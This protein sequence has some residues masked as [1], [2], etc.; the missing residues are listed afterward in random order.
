MHKK[1]VGA[2]TLTLPLVTA[3]GERMHSGEI[4]GLRLPD[5]VVE[6]RDGRQAG[7]TGSFES[8]AQQRILFGD[9]HVHTTFSADAFEASLPMLSGEGA[10]PPADAC[11]FAR[12]CA[13]LDFWA[14]TE[15]AEFLTPQRWREVQ[16]TVRQCDALGAGAGGPDLV[17]FLGWEWTQIGATPATHFGHKN[18][19]LREIDA[20]SAPVRPIAYDAPME[21]RFTV[22]L[23]AGGMFADLLKRPW[24]DFSNRDVYWDHLRYILE[25]FRVPRCPDGVPSPEL[26]ADCR[27][28]ASTPDVL[29]RKLREW[30]G[31]SFVIPHGNTWGLYTPPGTSWDKQLAGAMHDPERQTLIEVYSGHGSAEEYRDWR[32]IELDESGEAICP[33]PR[34]DFTPCCWQAGELARERCEDEDPRVCEELAREA[35]RNYV[36][37]GASGHLTL[38]D[39]EPE[40]WLDCGQCRDCFLPAFNHRPGSSVQA[41]LAT[42]RFENGAKQRFF[43]GLIASSD[44]H[45]ARPGTGYKEYARTRM[46]DTAGP[47]DASWAERLLD[48]GTGGATILTRPPAKIRI[49][50]PHAVYESERRAS[51]LSTGGLVAAHASSRSREAI[52]DA[53][54][55]REVYGTSGPRILL[56]F[57]LLNGFG[58]HQ[59]MGS[60]AQLDRVPRF[61]VRAAGAFEQRAGCPDS[62]SALRA[63]RLARLCAGECYHPSDRRHP[64]VRI[65]VVR[66]RAQLASDKDFGDRIDDPWRV[67]ECPGEGEGCEVEFEDPDFPAA[68]RDSLYYVR[69]IQAQTPAVNGAGLR[70]E[71]DEA[72]ACVRTRPCHGGF[73]T[74][75]DDDCLAPVEQRAWSSPIFLDHAA[76]R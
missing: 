25:T 45:S 34:P 60:R 38:P 32:A 72:G 49:A 37:A 11:D 40:E 12:Y 3:C 69:A 27:E 57:D 20:A 59:P 26:P 42:T 61:R 17:S 14:S 39:T 23:S 76:A 19:I 16:E 31:E 64:I 30:G 47:V 48:E 24:L 4:E 35:R 10:H 18:V 75:S 41:A 36:A 21:Q 53:L 6:A 13:D 33:E 70:C 51:Y 55:R 1:L 66:I 2:L 74:S 58:D 71:L 28:T 9:L 5:A 7:V 52:W 63:E 62:A 73:R 65:E 68:G 50:S 15:H 67:L 43:F 44:N 29:F 54:E 22:E 56:W 8:P 46:T